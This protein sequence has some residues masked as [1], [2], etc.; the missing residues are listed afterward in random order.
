MLEKLN[1]VQ[2]KDL[3]LD[4]IEA[5][6]GQTPVELIQMRQQYRSVEQELKGREAVYHELRK[7]VNS[8][9]LEIDSLA[10]RRK[11]S[12]EAALRAES[13]KEASQYQNQELQ[14]ATRL[15]ELEEDTLPLIEKLE[16]VAAEVSALKTHLAELEPQLIALNQAEEDRVIGIEENT[17]NLKLERESLA[18]TVP[19]ALL[20]QYEQVRRSKRGTGL[21]AIINN[22][23]C[24]GCNMQLP[25]H[26]M[27]KAKKGDAITKCPSCG[28]IL[29]DRLEV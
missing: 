14:F 17:I 25:I 15:Q 20:K 6:K 12:A 21:A 26:V 2:T 13:A 19:I 27:Q 3:E 1:D 22:K 16:A 10:A 5:E 29:W 11:A 18:A 28:R 4:A 23:R 24:G 7:Q 8:S 9:E